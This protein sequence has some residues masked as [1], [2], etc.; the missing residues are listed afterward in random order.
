MYKHFFKRFFDFLISLIG[1]IVISPLF[2]ILWISLSIANKGAGAFFTQKR[3]GKNEKIFKVIK[4]KT[5]TDERDAEGNLLPDVERLTKVG[6]FIRSTSLD[7]IPQLLNVIKGDMA[8]IGPRPLLVQYLPLYNEEQKRRHE[9]RPGITG[10]AQVNGRNLCKLSNKF[11]YDVWY[12]DN[13]SLK[14]DIKII[15]LTIKNV[16]LRKD[17]GAGNATMKEVDDLG[18]SKK[19]IKIN[20][21]NI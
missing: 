5:M 11:K 3:P 1:F 21:K 19:L 13:C 14:L 10:W 12:V 20:N 7:E 18:F 2:L 9:V 4:F 15:F 16:F 6:K 8:L 17:I